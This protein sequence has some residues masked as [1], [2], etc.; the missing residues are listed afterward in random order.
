MDRG[1]Y[2][3][4]GGV[5]RLQIKQGRAGAQ[6]GG[7]YRED[8]YPTGNGYTN[9]SGHGA[10]GRGTKRKRRQGTATASNSASTPGLYSDS[11][12]TDSPDDMD[13]DGNDSGMM[14]GLRGNGIGGLTSYGTDTGLQAFGMGN[15]TMM[16][17]PADDDY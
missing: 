4:A 9:G 8:P 3:P 12:G 5:E 6:A 1:L 15:N 11:P 17:R 13:L 14:S 10:G 2:G 7:R 16:P